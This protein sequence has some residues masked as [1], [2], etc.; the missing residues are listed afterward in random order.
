MKKLSTYLF[1]IFFTLQTLSWA[2]DITDFQIEGMS[3]GDS[4]LDYFSEE[5]IISNIVLNYEEGVFYKTELSTNN[6]KEYDLVGLYLKEKDKLYEIQGISG[7]KF[8]SKGFKECLTKKKKIEK[9]IS[10]LFKNLEKIDYGTSSPA[11]DKKTKYNQVVFTFKNDD[12]VFIT[13][14]DWS[15]KIEKENN[16]HD[17]LAVDMQSSELADFIREFTASKTKKFNTN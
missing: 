9:E 5:E 11:F 4:L 6:S 3:V 1:L 8:I 7:A 12:V 2:D 16:W 15:K 10:L 13:C 14:Y 17:N